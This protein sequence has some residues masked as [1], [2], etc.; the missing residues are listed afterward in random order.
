MIYPLQFEDSNYSSSGGSYCT[1]ST[2]YLLA[3]AL[4][5]C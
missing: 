4:A 1:C 3:S 5:S 2:W